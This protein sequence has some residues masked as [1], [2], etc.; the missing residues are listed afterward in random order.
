[1]NAM[2]VIFSAFIT[3]EGQKDPRADTSG[4]ARVLSK[5][6]STAGFCRK[7]N[8]SKGKTAFKIKWEIIVQF[9]VYRSEQPHQ[10]DLF[11]FL[12]NTEKL[13]LNYKSLFS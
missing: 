7:E 2:S 12:K 9:I 8:R 11:G 5:T 13:N 1:M 6:R 4:E 3:E 10:L